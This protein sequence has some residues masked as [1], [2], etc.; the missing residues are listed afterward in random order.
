MF[1]RKRRDLTDEE[2]LSGYDLDSPASQR[3]KPNYSVPRN[4]LDDRKTSRISLSADKETSL[5]RPHHVPHPFSFGRNRRDMD[6]FADVRQSNEEDSD[7]EEFSDPKLWIE[8]ISELYMNELDNRARWDP[9]WLNV[10]RRERFEGLKSVTVSVIDYLGNDKVERS[11][12]IT[13]KKDLAATINTRPEDSQVRVIMVSDL[14]RFVMG[15]LGQLYSIDP[16][17][18]YEQLITSGYCASDSGLKLRNA[19]W[20][21]W[22]ERETH[23]RHRPLPG[24]GQ[25][26][27]WNLSR[28]TKSRNW[29]HIRW[30]RLG[31]L[32]YL[33]RPG[34]HED[35]IAGRISDGRWTIERDV[36]V[37]RSGLLLTD[38]RKKRAE[39]KIQERKEKEE[40][41]KTKQKSQDMFAVPEP[42]KSTVKIEGTSNRVKTSN[43]YRPYSTFFPIL[44]QN[45][46]H[47]KNRDLRVM[48]PEGMGYWTSVDKEGK[49]TVILAFDPPRS[50]QNEKTKETTPSLTFMPRAMEFESYTEEELWRVAD[51]GETYLDPPVFIK[52]KQGEKGKSRKSG[53]DE[54]K[55]KMTD[56][57][58]SAS[59]NKEGDTDSIDTTDTE[60]DEEYQN[61]IKKSYR[62]RQSWVRDRDFARKYS[63]STLD[64][65][66]RYVSN[67]H[68]TELLQDDS[69]I[70]SLLARLSFDDTW[71]LLAELRIMQ[72]HIDSDLGADLHLHLLQDAGTAT[73]QNMAWIRS[74]LQELGEWV[75]HVKKSQRI[76]NLPE[77]LEQEMVELQEDLQSLQTRS[78]QTLN[79]L[80][81]STGI[82]QSALVIDQTSGINKLTELAFFFVPLSFITAVFSMQVA[83]LND[84]PPK[85]WTW[86]LSLSVVFVV[87]YAIRIFLR[88]PTVRYCVKAGRI[89]ILNRFTPK[90]RSMSLRLDSISNRAIAKFFF[91]LITTLSLSFSIVIIYLLSAFVVFFGLWAGIA[92]I[93]LYFIITRWPETA[94]LAPCFVSLVLAGGGITAVWYWGDIL[95]K[96]WENWIDNAVNWVKNIWPE[97]WM[98]DSV[99]DEDLDREG[100]PTYARQAM[101][102][103][104]K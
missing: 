32:H 39:R 103:P 101:F 62:S 58:A 99:D 20:M 11:K 98:T 80:V 8:T 48:A 71:Q 45:P 1:N 55:D 67:I 89:T 12:L 92:G 9:R 28:R 25:R 87:T 54:K 77:D 22:N 36:I 59:M 61:N 26:T 19:V 53:L 50:M 42:R 3:W 83:E 14:S 24:I 30:G 69:A 81:A 78:E 44:R 46:K 84:A 33:G 93:A 104:S 85:M 21:N 94:V 10:T 63:L 34:F 5:E 18:W 43:V 6:T 52:R 31:A 97:D 56:R 51:P 37:D 90:S 47:W 76:L 57:L 91:C 40:K 73:R 29:A 72:D 2:R 68:P 60:Y 88:S 35:E 27:E 17:F 95:E 75:D 64:L 82:S 49:K 7:N 96:A 74:I 16:E 70:P 66:S 102:L 23:F 79:F 38:K 4:S 100:V 65:V 86:G 41:K 13:T 15:V